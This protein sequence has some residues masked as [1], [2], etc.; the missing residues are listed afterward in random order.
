MKQLIKQVELH[1]IFSQCLLLITFISLS[2]CGNDD[3][4]QAEPITVEPIAVPEPIAIPEPV[5]IDPPELERFDIEQFETPVYAASDPIT[6]TAYDNLYTTLTYGRRP[7]SQ[8]LVFDFNQDGKLGLAD[9]N[10][11]ADNVRAD[12]FTNDLSYDLDLNGEVNDE[13][14]IGLYVLVGDAKDI[15]WGLLDSNRDG[16]ITRDDYEIDII[17]TEAFLL[18]TGELNSQLSPEATAKLRL[19]SGE[20]PVSM[21]MQ[22][23][24]THDWQL[25]LSSPS[26]RLVPLPTTQLNEIRA[27]SLPLTDDDQARLDAANTVWTL[28]LDA[29]K[30]S[31]SIKVKQVAVDLGNSQE[32]QIKLVDRNID[33]DIILLPNHI[34]I[35][36]RGTLIPRINS[37][38]R[39]SRSFSFIDLF[40]SAAHAN[41]KNDL[42]K[43]LLSP[44]QIAIQKQAVSNTKIITI[45]LQSLIKEWEQN[46]DKCKQI[47]CKDYQRL[48]EMLKP[49]LEEANTTR[50]MAKGMVDRHDRFVKNLG[51]LNKVIRSGV[52]RQQNVVMLQTLFSTISDIA[53]LDWEELVMSFK[54]GFKVTAKKLIKKGI[55][56]TGRAL[57][58]MAGDEL[59][60]RAGGFIA[61]VAVLMGD[62]SSD[63]GY[64]PF[65]F[66][67]KLRDKDEITGELGELNKERLTKR[68]GLAI[69]LAALK[70][71]AEKSQ[72]T[73]KE[74]LQDLQNEL[75]R[76]VND[77][78]RFAMLEGAYLGLYK[79]AWKLYNQIGDLQARLVVLEGECKY[80]RV[81]VVCSKELEQALLQAKKN[82]DKQLAPYREKVDGLVQQLDQGYTASEQ[83]LK[84]IRD[85]HQKLRDS[86]KRAGDKAL[87]Q[88]EQA[89][90]QDAIEQ[91]DE[92]IAKLKREQKQSGVD[93]TATISLL[94]Q[95]KL[96]YQQRIN[97][98]K[99]KNKDNAVV[100]ELK[101][102][103]QELKKLW[104]EQDDW[105]E[106][107]R[108]LNVQLKQ[109]R[110]ELQQEINKADQNYI[111]AARK[112]REVFDKCLG[113]AVSHISSR[114]K[115]DT[116]DR[117]DDVM[118]SSKGNL[119]TVGE[120]FEPLID[121]QKRFIV[122]LKTFKPEYKKIKGCEKV[123]QPVSSQAK[124]GS[125]QCWR[126]EYPAFVGD[127][128]LYQDGEKISAQVS[129]GVIEGTG[130]DDN[131]A[132][133]M[134]DEKRVLN[135]VG[136]LKGKQLYLEHVFS[137]NSRDFLRSM[138]R[139]EYP[140]AFIDQMIT[141]GA[142]STIE[143]E[144]T[145]EDIYGTGTTKK[146][147]QGHYQYLDYDIEPYSY[148][149][150]RCLQ[151]N[152]VFTDKNHCLYKK[153]SKL[154]NNSLISHGYESYGDKDVRWIQLDP[155]AENMRSLFVHRK[156]EQGSPVTSGTP[157]EQTADMGKSMKLGDKV[158][159]G[160]Q[161]SMSILNNCR[162]RQDELTVRIEPEKTPAKGFTVVLKE[163]SKHSGDYRS[164]AN[165]TKLD[166]AA[167]DVL[168]DNGYGNI[169][170]SIVGATKY[171]DVPFHI[172]MRIY[173]KP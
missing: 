164:D 89:V 87:G 10:E 141:L 27:L 92:D 22:E 162:F 84:K 15:G 29:K 48:Q 116:T 24:N 124:L 157:I 3:S 77:Y 42:L 82:Y 59:G 90:L 66:D 12:K 139:E 70:I 113:E 105:L 160:T 16:H 153:N 37:D 61:D 98:L 33:N 20:H 170:F 96:E 36:T 13:D 109:A 108:K 99:E 110:T 39:D 17:G 143:G 21:A 88:S 146:V 74:R 127:V 49:L 134:I 52:N 81:E 32:V 147:M 125:G 2:G 55:A 154:N 19:A 46:K 80:K 95:K 45:K 172:F 145:E 135:Y 68:A 159:L 65:G 131:P 62:Y 91:L 120:I 166:F 71:W 119:L 76:A 43:G 173:E 150:D 122:E 163:T 73:E 144:I 138:I 165:G 111:I 5:P 7:F 142:K 106:N 130:E 168:Y 83:R 50:L 126:I 152:T 75:K 72:D 117:T 40:I 102:K 11:F 57:G 18:L 9:V 151:A 26:M 158:W 97:K 4:E 132:A 94:A 103:Q 100:K 85:T 31:G 86:R 129:H 79:Q 38:S 107:K 156:P 118:K 25:I 149:E 8:L 23:S 53:V 104:K 14:V 30:V 161:D 123:K 58:D 64:F 41:G 115:V 112:A 155:I 35:G 93:A 171:Q 128:L 54:K 148:G 51:S 137:E 6:Q 101:Q 63:G 114:T 121:A 69:A 167:N 133:E 28:S 56:S 78:Q 60:K 140:D 136:T 47:S 44:E 169:H 67:N 1:H 34:L